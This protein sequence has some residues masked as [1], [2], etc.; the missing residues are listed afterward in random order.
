MFQKTPVKRLESCSCQLFQVAMVFHSLDVVYHLDRRSRRLA[1]FFRLTFFK[2]FSVF[3][4]LEKV[5]GTEVRP[6]RSG[7][8]IH[9]AGHL[10]LYKNKIEL[11]S[12]SH[13]YNVKLFR[14]GSIFT[15]SKT[16]PVPNPWR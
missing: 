16:V 9:L 7:G 14:L 3:C 5:H 11:I 15:M 13:R 10:H 12:L 8:F 2:S 4:G 1:Y 6:S